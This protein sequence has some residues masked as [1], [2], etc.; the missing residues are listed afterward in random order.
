M[1]SMRYI[2]EL[3][4]FAVT[5]FVA[6]L[7]YAQSTANAV[8][9]SVDRLELRNV[10]AEA[11]TYNNRSAIRLID[12]ASPE[13]G[14]AG[15]LAILRETS[16]TD[17]TIEVDLTGDTTPDAAPTARGFVGISFRVSSDASRFE[18]FYLRPKNGRAPD[19]L[20]RNHSTQYISVPGFGWQKLRT[21]TPG[22]YESYVDL[23]PGEWTNMKIFVTGDKAQLYVKNAAQP[24]LIV[25][26]LKQPKSPGSVAL[27][28][29]PGT[30]A[31]F[32]NMKIMP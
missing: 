10:K 26:D 5:Q 27:W 30:I 8:K 4:L 18:T 15:R 9:L 17:G 24:C 28:I 13:L 3:V 6:A 21:E 12:A 2:T 29:G 32:A 14:D 7:M 31:H 11:V 1:R 16:F 23:I 25:N 19:Q 20:Q 22:K